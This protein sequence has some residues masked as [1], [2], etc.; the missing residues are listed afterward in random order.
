[1]MFLCLSPKVAYSDCCATLNSEDGERA[2]LIKNHYGDWGIILGK[3]E[4][5]RMGVP[6]I[7]GK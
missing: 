5:A 7:P 2:V 3:W 6:G 1:M 4:G